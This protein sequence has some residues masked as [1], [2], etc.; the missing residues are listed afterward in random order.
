MNKAHE[1]LVDA[2]FGPRAKAYVESA[3]HARG[4]DLEALEVVVSGVRPARA[5]DLGT[6]G[7]HVAYLMARHAGSVTA[8]DLSREMLAAVAAAAKDRGLTN[9]EVAEA[10]AER[11]TFDD[12]WFDFLGCRYSAHHWR[13][14]E[15]GLREARRVLK[16]GS[17]AVFIDAF[18]PEAAAL[19]THLQAVELLRDT[20]HVRD[21]ASSEWV[22]ALNRSGFALQ[23]FRSW[24]IRLDFPTW[25]ARMQTPPDNVR[26]IR[27]LQMAASREIR[28][29]F[30]IEAD[31]SFMLD[32]T[33][34]ETKAA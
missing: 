8:S 33:M 17:K 34:I 11:L 21:Y 24:R 25:I 7:G 12:V 22:A 18:A 28:D 20:S 3:V 31:G 10:S 6:G 23:A 9:V 14:L 30:E 13:N 32:V 29:H 15:A 1:Q 19:D 2:Q 4:P 26:A 5:L 27:A 16:H